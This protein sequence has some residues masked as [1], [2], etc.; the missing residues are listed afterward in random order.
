MYQQ[1]K[2]KTKEGQRQKQSHNKE[3]PNEEKSMEEQTRANEE[4]DR[5]TQ[6]QETESK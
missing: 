4:N 1:Q 6:I 2:E 5:N 3:I